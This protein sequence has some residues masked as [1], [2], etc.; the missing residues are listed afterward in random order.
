MLAGQPRAVRT[1]RRA[2]PPLSRPS[3][4]SARQV[5]AAR[6]RSRQ[7]APPWKATKWRATHA[8]LM[9]GLEGS[10]RRGRAGAAG[11]RPK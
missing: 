8:S 1:L 2:R 10:M 5:P 11:V 7:L 3:A 6:K 9:F 4:S